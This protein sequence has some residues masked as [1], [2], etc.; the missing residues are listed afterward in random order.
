[1]NSK[2]HYLPL[3]ALALPLL[4]V[5]G[6]AA[7]VAAANAADITAAYGIAR[8]AVPMQ[9]LNLKAAEAETTGDY[10][11][12]FD[13]DALI[14]NA[15]R[16]LN[17]LTFKSAYGEQK[18]TGFTQK[19]DR[20]LYSDR[21]DHAFFA[22]AGE[23]VRLSFDFSTDW[24]NGFVY[25]DRDNDG[26]FSFDVGSDHRPAAGS[27]VMA[28][29]F[30]YE[31]NSDT[32]G[33]NSDGTVINTDNQRSQ[34]NPPA[35]TIPSDL[36]PGYYRMR[37]KVDWGSLDPG[38]SNKSGQTILG[39][40][41][42]IVDLRLNVHGE[43]ANVSLVNG[44][45][46]SVQIDGQTGT[47]NVAVPF[48]KDLTLT[49]TP[50][51]ANAV[52]SAVRVRHGYNLDGDSLIHGTPQYIDEVYP[53]YLIEGDKLTIPGS[54]VD[55]DVRITPVFIEQETGGGTGEGYYPINFDK[56][57]TITN[58]ERVLRSVGLSVEGG[59]SITLNV[60]TGTKK[61]YNSLTS[62]VISAKPGSKFTANIDY[63]GHEHMHAYL[64][65]DLNRNGQFLPL[66]NADGTP[67]VSS[68]LLAYTYYNGKD[69]NGTEKG[70][71]QS[72][73][74]TTNSLAFQLPSGLP[75]G[76]YRA[77]LKIDW[78]NIDPAG[79]TSAAQ[80][81][82]KNGGYIVDFVI[83]SV[84]KTSAL[85]IRTANGSI[86]GSGNTGMPDDVTS[87]SALNF[88]T[89]PAASGYTTEGITV[90]HGYNLDEAQTD[91]FGNLQ[92][93]EFTLS[94]DA[95][96]VPA[97]SVYGE[98]RLSADFVPNGTE[99]Y[100]L[101]FS[102]EFNQPDGSM[103][104]S[105]KWARS[106][107]EH[108]TWK[109][110]VSTTPEGQALTAFIKDGKLVTR[111]IPNTLESEGDVDMISGSIESSSTAY[112]TYGKVE[113]R[114]KTIPHTG[115]F[116]AFWMMPKENGGKGWPWNGEIDIW[117]QIDSQ[118]ISHHTIHTGW[119]NGSAD[120]GLGNS[121]NPPKAGPYSGCKNGQWHTF[122][123][124][125]DETSLKWY[126]DGKHVFTYNKLVNNS[127]AL[128]NGQ[129][130][131]DKDF[132][133]ILNQS[134]GNGSWAAPADVKFTYETL[135]DW[136]RVYQKDGQSGTITGL[137]SVTSDS[138]SVEVEAGNGSLT[139]TSATAAPVSVFD[140]SG[141]SVFSGVVS[142][143]KTL[144]LASGIYVAAG[145]KV[146]VK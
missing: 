136:V 100:K 2:R 53:G 19:T 104:D 10:P 70:W 96:S 135:F 57:L 66:L 17:G 127:Y 140:V 88:L 130:P 120:G 6:H 38:G 142:G 48:G 54:V 132:Y 141:R 143:S 85:D 56:D 12:N 27:D 47:E 131:F 73:F 29:S 126:V 94:P 91:K 133:I 80:A 106:T 117:E 50:A 109:R 74:P 146:L 65:L 15:N 97:D 83:N 30:Y 40:G 3:M 32:S 61:V 134:V 60:P 63:T 119:A 14:T 137:S 28:Y 128:Q 62:S 71:E 4:A 25:I 42:S 93:S 44:E 51:K 13:K 90:R 39:N 110:F 115:N 77:R 35:F 34:I 129:W 98:V 36:K 55:G 99:E 108:P 26:S 79:N 11:L 31:G 107:R 116:P 20:K 84:G 21:L 1:M 144:S 78:D 101:W 41:G 111:C 33:W 89:V 86:V 8:K 124:E 18:L 121:N 43:T 112:F 23:Q 67:A 123:L 52:L 102:D 58:G 69:S 16:W 105:K 64:Y 7:P 76:V 114:I 9:A 145:Q 75:A 103:P 92:W 138:P 87:L 118:D 81:M 37:C 45:L 5:T 82:D 59:S 122:S 125:W 24:M 139:L 46:G 72:G 68:E 113:G 22:K 49:I 95:T